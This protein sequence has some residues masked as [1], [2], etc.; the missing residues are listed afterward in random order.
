MERSI[1]LV[2]IMDSIVK[3]KWRS[4]SIDKFVVHSRTR[5]AF[6]EKAVSMGIH[7]DHFY[8]CSQVVC[9]VVVNDEKIETVRM[10]RTVHIPETKKN[11][12]IVL[13]LNSAVK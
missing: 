4:K 5:T 11:T 10:H 9:D 3:L 12:K 13:M 2:R 8:Q 6:S 7:A 1:S